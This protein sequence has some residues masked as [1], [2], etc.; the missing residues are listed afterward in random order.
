MLGVYIVIGIM[1]IILIYK[2]IIE[3]NIRYKNV[4]EML[5]KFE[6]GEFLLTPVKSRT[7]E[8]KLENAEIILLI[9][10]LPIPHNSAVTINSKYTWRLQWGGSSSKAGRPYPRS[11][12][13]NEMIPFL[14]D[15][16]KSDKKVL[17]VTLLYPKTEKVLRYLNESDLD[18]IEPKDTPHGYK[19]VSFN[20]FEEYFD[21]IINIK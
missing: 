17:K 20:E 1:V 15:V 13:L 6:E 3:P 16:V 12:Y 19:V 8:F 4:Y 18:I 11:R 7:F 10:V 2:I 9:K 14:K 21:D 5:E